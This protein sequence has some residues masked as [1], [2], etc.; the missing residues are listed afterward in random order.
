[1]LVGGARQVDPPQLTTGDVLFTAVTCNENPQSGDPVQAALAEF[2]GETGGNAYDVMA[3]R[4]RGGVDC[5]GWPA[6]SEPVEI[7]GSGLDQQPL[8]LQSQRDAITPYQGGVEMAKELGGV[9]VTVQG[10]DHGV[11]ARGNEPVD[12]LVT[13]YLV[14]GVTPK[15]QVLPEAPI[16][17]P[18][19]PPMPAPQPSG[20]Q[21]AGQADAAM[22]QGFSAAAGAVTRAAQDVDQAVAQTSGA[23]AAQALNGQASAGAGATDQGPAVQGSADQGPTAQGGPVTQAVNDVV[24]QVGAALG[25]Q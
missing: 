3:Q 20:D 17:T 23:P 21:A 10:G 8:V 2:N 1:T 25:V 11:F 15:P 5:A 14:E 18:L 19:T 12:E 6:S 16:R 4:A 13:D 22:A 24:D 9:L 7:D